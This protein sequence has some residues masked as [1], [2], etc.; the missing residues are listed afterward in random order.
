MKKRLSIAIHATI[1]IIC[2]LLVILVFVLCFFIE[3]IASSG[4]LG[5][6]S[7]A[8]L[9]VGIYNIAIAIKIAKG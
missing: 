9:V 1:G 7:A 5:S 2:I 6:V 3:A 8:T 4:I